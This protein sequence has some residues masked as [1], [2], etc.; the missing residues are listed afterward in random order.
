MKKTIITIMIL[1]L[2]V[3]S[4]S[5]ILMAENKVKSIDNNEIW[6][7]LQGEWEKKDSAFAIIKG[8]KIEYCN[9]VYQAPL[10]SKG[11]I[12]IIGTLDSYVDNEHE[13]IIWFKVKGIKMIFNLNGDCISEDYN[14]KNDA[15]CCIRYPD[16][17]TGIYIY[18]DLQITLT[19][20]P[21]EKNL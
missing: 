4:L 16:K 20:S 15:F 8:K 19:K 13:D 6:N 2:A 14:Y 3:L 10:E 1:F 9:T 5:T 7:L 18:D 11:Y 21:K 12:S 17:L